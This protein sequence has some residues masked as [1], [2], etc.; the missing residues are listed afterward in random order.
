MSTSYLMILTR[1]TTTQRGYQG[2]PKPSLLCPGISPGGGTRLG[3]SCLCVCDLL[4]RPKCLTCEDNKNGSRETGDPQKI[5]KTRGV[6]FTTRSLHGCTCC[7]QAQ[8]TE[9][10]RS[11][12]GTATGDARGLLLFV[13]EG[14]CCRE[15]QGR[16]INF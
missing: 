14:F 15:I 11:R 13:R 2:R 6:V 4:L 3:G 9:R 7:G 10:L 16:C 8:H 12:E 1:P 5:L